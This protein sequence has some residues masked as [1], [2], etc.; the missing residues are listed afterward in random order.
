MRVGERRAVDARSRPPRAGGCP[1]APRAAPTGRCRR[2]RRCRRSRRRAARTRRPSTRVTPR[3]SRDREAARLQDDRRR[4]GPAP[5]STLQDDL[6]PDHRV[7]ELGRRWSR[8]SRKSRPSRRAASPRR[9]RSALMISRSLWVMKTIVLFCDFRTRSIANSWSASDGVS[10]AVGSSRTR[11]SAPRTSAFRISTRCCRPTDNSPTI[12]SGSTSS[13]YSLA[14]D[15]SSLARTARRR[16]R[17][18]SGAA[19]GAEH[20]VLE[21]GE[22]RHQHEMLVH[23]ADAVADRLARATDAHGFAVDADLAG[24]GLVEAVE[25]RHQRRLAGAVLADDAVDRC[26]ARR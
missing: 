10:T 22:R 20:H 16:R 4:D 2:R 14:R 3:S 1:P 26:R 25:D 5:F 15:R 19:F 23:H 9:G 18:S 12:A 17:A 13:A 24:V 21:H 8:P 11:M 6:A 7:G